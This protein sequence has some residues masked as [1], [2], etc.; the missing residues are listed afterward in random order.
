MHSI[1]NDDIT[2]QNPSEG[3]NKAVKPACSIHCAL[4]VDCCICR[5]WST[6]QFG[7]LLIYLFMLIQNSLARTVF[8]TP[9]TCHITPLLPSLHWLKIKE[10]IEY[11]YKLL[12]LTYNI[13]TTSQ[14][15]YLHNLVSLQ[16]PRGTS[17]SSITTLSRPESRNARNLVSWFS[18]KL[19]KL[20]PPDVRF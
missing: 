7:S 19:L 16:S 17:S 20:L 2:D 18:G 13:L 5:H 10:R 3:A 12:S 8:N 1:S 11:R 15:T 4:F 6:R 14:T 9:K